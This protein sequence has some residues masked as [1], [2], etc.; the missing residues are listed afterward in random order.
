VFCCHC[1]CVPDQWLW[2][3]QQQQPP[4]LYQ[5]VGHKASGPQIRIVPSLDLSPFFRTAGLNNLLSIVYRAFCIKPT[6]THSAAANTHVVNCQASPQSTRR[7]NVLQWLREKKASGK[8]GD[9]LTKHNCE[10]CRCNVDL[11][12][13]V[14]VKDLQEVAYQQN[15]YTYT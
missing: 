13:S 14:S 8:R 12:W 9:N 10:C 2:H 1:G 4:M 11:M 5:V 15:F 6:D 7:L 3:Q